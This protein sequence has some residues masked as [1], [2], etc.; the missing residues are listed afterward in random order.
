MADKHLQPPVR[1]CLRSGISWLARYRTSAFGPPGCQTSER[2][3]V[4]QAVKIVAFHCGACRNNFFYITS[5]LTIQSMN[6]TNAQMLSLHVV[7]VTVDA[8]VSLVTV[9]L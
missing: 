4:K 7:K 6:L 2:K 9:L 1:R 5:N 8:F 3:H